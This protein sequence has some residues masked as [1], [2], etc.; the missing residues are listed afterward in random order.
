MF[1]RI[2]A[3]GLYNGRCAAL[4]SQPLVMQVLVQ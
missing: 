3:M 4:S 2:I 1:I